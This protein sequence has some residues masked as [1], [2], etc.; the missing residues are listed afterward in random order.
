MI[1]GNCLQMGTTVSCG[2][3]SQKL[4]AKGW[5]AQRDRKGTDMEVYWK[6]AK[7]SAIKRGYIF[8][9]S[10]EDAIQLLSMQGNTCALTRWPITIEGVRKDKATASLDRIDSTKGYTKDNTQWVHKDLNWMKQ[11]FAQDYFIKACTAVAHNATNT[12]KQ[13][14]RSWPNDS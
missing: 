12:D 7:R 4:L 10:V 1:S 11:S 3:Y 6:R 8:D 2:C 13:T 14:T 9:L 5:Q